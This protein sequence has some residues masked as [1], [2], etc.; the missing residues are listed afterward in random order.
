M[1]IGESI[2]YLF[3]VPLAGNIIGMLL[4]FFSL[5]FKIIKLKDVKPASDVLIK[6]M[7]VFFIP[8]GV[9]LMVYVDMIKEIW[10]PITVATIFSL[11]LCLYVTGF[12]MQKFS[13]K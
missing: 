12:V 13:K 8:Y 7:V 3:S 11:L 1:F 6:Y 9:G 2:H 4:I 10:L 5:Y